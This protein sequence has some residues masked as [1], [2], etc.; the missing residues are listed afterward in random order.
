VDAIWHD[1]VSGYT[2]VCYMDG[3]NLIGS[4]CP[5]IDIRYPVR[6]SSGWTFG[7]TGDFDYDGRTDILWRNANSG[8]HEVWYLNDSLTLTGWAD[9]ADLVPISSGWRYVASGDFNRDGKVDV[10]WHHSG[11]SS[12]VWYLNGTTMTYQEA[13]DPNYSV[14]EYSGWRPFQVSDFNYD[15]QAD[16]LWHHLGGALSMWFMNGVTMGYW[17]NPPYS[18]SDYSGWR[19]LPGN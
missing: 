19:E 6:D 13:V 4:S 1:G 7:G 15:G 14:P 9:F 17:E 16:I 8:Y 3:V 2:A 12:V 10:L 5:Y 11:G 18:V